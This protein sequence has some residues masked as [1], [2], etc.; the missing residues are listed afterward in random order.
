MEVG[1]DLFDVLPMGHDSTL[2]VMADVMG[3]GL[4]ASLFAASLRTLLRALAHGPSRPAELLTELN[5][6]MFDQLSS[7]DMFIT[8]QL[9]LADLLG[10]QLHI[11]NAGHCPL[12]ISDGTG[13]TR[14]VAPEG[15]P[16]GIQSNTTFNE[17]S[18]QMPP[19]SSVLLYTD[20]V[21]EA[22]DRSGGLFGQVRLENWFH[23]AVA[24]GSNCIELK[25]ELL[26]ELATFQG[27]DSPADDQTFL[28]LVDETPRPSGIYLNGPR[29]LPVYEV[30]GGPLRRV[31]AAARTETDRGRR[32][33][34]NHKAA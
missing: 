17:E 27:T 24:R 15:M 10:H 3:K 20:G 2:L 14:A 32:V 19:F 18:V 25:Q 21:T 6:L 34:V 22:R 8:L 31:E 12:L 23:R 1:G 16:L 13:P 28:I 4:P 29:Y 33:G 11:A 9:V 5:H 7:E 30:P 26:K